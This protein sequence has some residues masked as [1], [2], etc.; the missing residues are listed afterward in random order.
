MPRTPQIDDRWDACNNAP[1]RECA[2]WIPLRELSEQAPAS[3]YRELR[4]DADPDDTVS[5]ST[6]VLARMATWRRGR[7]CR[8]SL[9]GLPPSAAVFSR[10]STLQRWR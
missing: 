2:P 9:L 3:T 1:Y 6:D 5:D 10:A 4:I 8:N 7:M